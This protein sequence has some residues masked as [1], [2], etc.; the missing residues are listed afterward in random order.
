MK[1]S[2]DIE[3]LWYRCNRQAGSPRAD[4]A[5]IRQPAAAAQKRWAPRPETPGRPWLFRDLADRGP[6]AQAAASS[7]PASQP[8]SS[9]VDPTSAARDATPLSRD[10]L[11]TD[12]WVAMSFMPML[13]SYDCC[14]NCCIGSIRQRP[15][16][17]HSSMHV[18]HSFQAPLWPCRGRRRV[19]R[20][21][22]PATA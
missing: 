13:L 3:T 8:E 1:R 4:G 11:L 6:Q 16:I 14:S 7:L 22:R 12:T 20:R 17:G 19:A 10:L 15:P 9:A 2:F 21:R 18:K 5:Q